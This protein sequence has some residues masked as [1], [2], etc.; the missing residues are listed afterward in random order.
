MTFNSTTNFE[1]PV[2]RHELQNTYGHDASWKS[3]GSKVSNGVRA[4]DNFF[5]TAH[6]LTNSL[7]VQSGNDRN[8]TYLS[9][10]NT[11]ANSI[12][13]KSASRK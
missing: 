3:W 6:T 1:N 2:Y 4:A 9:Y 5:E 11:T 10:G 7:S 8:Q 13:G 12:L